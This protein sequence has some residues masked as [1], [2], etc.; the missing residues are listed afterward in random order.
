MTTEH[1]YHLITMPFSSLSATQIATTDSSEYYH[2]D[3]NILGTTT[4]R[5]RDLK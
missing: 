1:G 4:A 2:D 3:N 5:K